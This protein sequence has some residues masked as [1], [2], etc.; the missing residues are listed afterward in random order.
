MK[1]FTVKSYEARTLNMG[2]DR[3]SSRY[4]KGNNEVAGEDAFYG[5]GVSLSL[6]LNPIEN[7]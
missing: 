3:S 6:D 5:L 7:L 4:C 2:W 1:P